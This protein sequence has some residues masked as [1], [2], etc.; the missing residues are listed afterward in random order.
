MP[1]TP[2]KIGPFAGGLNA[3]SEPT[4]VGDNECIDILNFDIDLDGSLYS[5]APIT[6]K[7]VA[8]SIPGTG[9]MVLHGFFID[10]DGDRY[11]FATTTSG[12]YVR[13][14]ETGAWST[15]TTTLSASV[16]VQYA[17]KMYLVPD[18]AEA[19]P[20][21]YW[22]PGG[23][24]VA[25]AAI[26]KG[27]TACI[28]KERL[29]IGGG[30]TNP[31]RVYFSDAAN[32]SAFQTTINFFDVRAGDGQDVVMLYTF[33]D[34]VV[35]LKDDSTYVYSYDSAPSRGVVRL[36]NGAVGI[37]NK[38]CLVEHEN[39]LYIHYESV[40]YQISNW[41]FT[42]T[43][44]KVPFKYTVVFPSYGS[45]PSLSLMS[46]RVIV[47]HFDAI[48]VF[49]LRVGAWTIWSV[50]EGRLFNHFIQVPRNAAEEPERYYAGCRRNA[51]G[52]NRALFE[53]RP[54]ADAIRSEEMEVYVVS[55]VFD[56]NVAYTFKRL[57]W[58]GVDLLAKRN[59]N[60]TVHPVAYTTS[61]THDQLSAYTHNAIP[62][63]HLRPLDMSIA[64]SGGIDP[65]SN[66]A[67]NR[68][69]IKLLK[70]LRFRQI[71]FTVGG[72]TDGSTLTG[73]TR[74]YSLVAFI[75]NKQLVSK[76]VS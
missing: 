67:G 9:P 22:T 63:N 48:Y 1:S 49:N 75:D 52:A 71:Y 56:F 53:W 13:N 3:Y 54:I 24:F 57:F 5:R 46:D 76:Q 40:L 39:S 58:W 33:S 64:I 7:D 4:S 18:P 30:T 36:I 28:Y 62:G 68:M 27:T 29:F 8:A 41:N 32:F 45:E 59:M 42:A 10:T 43:N 38:N 44:I 72:T 25:V 16:C 66:S 37:T 6:I 74:I 73:P 11:L 12:T 2:V 35:V 51:A 61:V 26:P 23:G 14:E 55:K 21:G 60:Y 15:V 31:N 34:T 19:D 20:G 65:I 17:N 69:F 47:H 70:S 50:A